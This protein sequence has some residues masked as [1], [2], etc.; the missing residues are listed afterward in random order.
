MLHSKRPLYNIRMTGCMVC[1]DGDGQ[2]MSAASVQAGVLQNSA[3]IRNF[4]NMSGSMV[5]AAGDGVNGSWT[6]ATNL[7]RFRGLRRDHQAGS[8][9]IVTGKVSV[10]QRSA[11]QTLLHSFARVPTRGRLCKRIAGSPS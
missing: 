8:A 5:A 10:R 11:V 1:G 9:G 7:T 3:I 6:F 2:R 4:R